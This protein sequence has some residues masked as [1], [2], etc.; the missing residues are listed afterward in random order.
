M[1]SQGAAVTFTIPWQNRGT[2]N[3]VVEVMS[4]GD[5]ANRQFGIG[6][7]LAGLNLGSQAGDS[8]VT[9]LRW[10]GKSGCRHRRLFG[11]GAYVTESRVVYARSWDC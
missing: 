9:R 8:N 1:S 11:V 4:G 6:L 10:T 2:H 7:K 3:H 5:R